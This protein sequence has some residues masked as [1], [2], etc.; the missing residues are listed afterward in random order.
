MTEAD[1]EKKGPY[2]G[3][4]IEKKAA[5]NE[6][7]QQHEVGIIKHADTNDAD[8]AYKVFA[9]QAGEHLTITPEE[10]RRLLKKIDWNLSECSLFSKSECPIADNPRR[11]AS[12]MSLLWA[13]LS[14]QDSHLLCEC[15][16]LKGK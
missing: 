5:S 15:H 10:E 4:D 7:G 6:P 11:S 16:G 1:L 2:P 14:R 3:D 13:Q 12:T 8:E 9:A